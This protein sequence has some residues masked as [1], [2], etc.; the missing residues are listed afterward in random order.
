MNEVAL[1]RIQKTLGSDNDEYLAESLGITTDELFSLYH[2]GFIPH[3]SVISELCKTSGVSADYILGLSDSK[4]NIQTDEE[5]LID[6][7]RKLGVY[8]K[9]QVDGVLSE[10]ILQQERDL[11]MKQSVAADESE[12][13][14]GTYNHAK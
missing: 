1:S 2:Y 3:I 6:N 7:Y 14:T 8:Y 13:K 5:S 12:P 10:Q 4:L 9:N 11:F